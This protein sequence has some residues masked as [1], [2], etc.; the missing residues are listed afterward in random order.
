MS[1]PSYRLFDHQIDPPLRLG[2]IFFDV[3]DERAIRAIVAWLATER[4][5]WIVADERP[6]H[7]LLLAH[8][9]R[10]G[11]DPDRAVL[12]LASD[13]EFSARLSYGDAMPPLTLRKP[14]QPMHLKIGLE[15]AAASL[16]PEQVEALG[17]QTRPRTSQYRNFERPPTLA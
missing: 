3:A 13:A 7:A 2:L 5:P 8:G 6:H 17:P 16:I 4:L 10:R 1:L 12:R 9:P 15:M 14:L 11:A